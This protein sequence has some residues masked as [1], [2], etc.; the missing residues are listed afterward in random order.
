MQWGA[1]PYSFKW[2]IGDG[3]NSTDSGPK[4]SHMFD[5]A[6]NYTITL[7]GERFYTPSLNA[8]A[9]IVIRVNLADNGTWAA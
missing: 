7:K 6:G 3:S 5:R 9:N 1:A 2:I 4:V 8:S